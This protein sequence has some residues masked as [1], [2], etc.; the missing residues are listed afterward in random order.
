MATDTKISALPV[1]GTL[2]GA[3][4][5]PVVQD[6]QTVRTSLSQALNSGAATQ[7]QVED[8]VAT[9]KWV[10]PAGLSQFW[11]KV[12]GAA[13]SVS[14]L[15][16]FTAGLRAGNL[17]VDGSSTFNGALSAT[18]QPV[19]VLN[20]TDV[21]TRKSMLNALLYQFNLKILPMSGL[22]PT[23]ANTLNS[24]REATFPG[25]L[26]MSVGSQQGSFYQQSLDANCGGDAVQYTGTQFQYPFAVAFAMTHYSNISSNGTMR[27]VLQIGRYREENDAAFITNSGLGV[28]FERRN[29]TSGAQIACRLFAKRVGQ[30]MTYSPWVVPQWGYGP[31]NFILKNLGNGT[32]ELW[33]S[34][35][36]PMN[37][38]NQL[39]LLATISDGPNQAPGGG[40]SMLE[41][42]ARHEATEG[43]GF[44]SGFC[45]QIVVATGDI[46]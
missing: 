19:P 24:S 40:Q 17:T 8:A 4:I 12:K 45:N 3:E 20:N 31:L 14:G 33:R 22:F 9:D 15:W 27:W 7:Q 10:S 11:N 43:D 30:N 36:G 2:N 39:T 18:G 32:S 41:V 34:Y 38:G 37:E 28:E 6:G 29:D 1:A 46:F 13:Q 42:W 25:M 44:I 16:N 21:L 35:S 23:P 26:M 5:L